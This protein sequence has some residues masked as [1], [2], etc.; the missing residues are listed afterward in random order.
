MLPA[1]R[2][3]AG[4]GRLN[5]EMNNPPPELDGARVLKYAVLTDEIRNTGN[6]WHRVNGLDLPKV[7]ALAICKYDDN[8]DYYIFYCDSDWNVMTD[9]CRETLDAALGSAE[10]EYKGITKHWKDFA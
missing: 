2:L 10:L 4:R 3:C 5:A 8:E 7:Y 1:R 6:V 9:L